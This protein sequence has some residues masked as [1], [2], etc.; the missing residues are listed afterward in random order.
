MGEG[1]MTIFDN[2]FWVLGTDTGIGK[3]YVT[4]L[5]ALY[6]QAQSKPFSVCK[7]VACGTYDLMGDMINEDVEGLKAIVTGHQTEDEICPWLLSQPLAPWTAAQH[8]GV[9]LSAEDIAAHVKKLHHTFGMVIAEGAGG[10]AVPLNGSESYLDAVQRSSF[11]VVLVVGMKLGCI[12]HCL[13]S[14]EALKKRGIEIKAVILN[15]YIKELPEDVYESSKREISHHCSKIVEIPHI[16][17]YPMALGHLEKKS[18]I[19]D[20]DS[21]VDID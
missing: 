17:S 5:L 21:F 9:S 10:V 2:S 15:K 7:P 12:N 14:I 6:R 20:F 13:L 11:P 19:F 16:S 4:S 1:H 3:T 8:D 18:Q